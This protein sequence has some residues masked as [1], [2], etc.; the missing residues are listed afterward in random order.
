M[1]EGLVTGK[2]KN[3]QVEFLRSLP[4]GLMITIIDFGL[5]ILLTEHFHVHYLT[6]AAVGF[7]AGQLWSY[8]MCVHWVF[9]KCSD[10]S[11][12]SRF[13]KFLL[14]SL[15]GLAITEVFLWYFTE[16]AEV[17]YVFSKMG[18]SAVSSL[19]LFVMRKKLL[20]S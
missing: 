8:F 13:M 10:D 18:A 20:F 17:F 11:H 19:V 4:V 12:A 5:L 3:T 6:S 7:L 2:A 14:I 1:V 16:K 9:A 15:I